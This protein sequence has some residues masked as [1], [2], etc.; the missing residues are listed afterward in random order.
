MIL[1]TSHNLTLTSVNNQI[2]VCI[3]IDKQC[4]DCP[5]LK[6]CKFMK[7]GDLIEKD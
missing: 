3:R 5:F 2:I 6:V 7:G 1:D 4:D